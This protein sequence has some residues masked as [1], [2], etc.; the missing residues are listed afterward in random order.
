[1]KFS[2]LKGAFSETGI[3]EFLRNLNYGRGSS[4]PLKAEELPKIY[5]T[6]PWDGKDAEQPAEEDIDLSD[7][8]L[9]E[10]DEL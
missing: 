8:V 7:V 10:K 2:L 4:A 5:E 9:D 6:E 1:M 3:N